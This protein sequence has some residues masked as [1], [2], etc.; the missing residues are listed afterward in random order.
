VKRKGELAVARE[1]V[2]VGGRPALVLPRAPAR[3]AVG[4]DLSGGA[5]D[6]VF[7]G[8]AEEGPVA[9]VRSKRILEAAFVFPV[10]HRTTI[11]CALLVRPDAV[12]PR[13]VAAL[14]G[15]DEVQR[16]WQAVLARGMRTELPAPAQE[17]VDAA[18]AV[19][20]LD[21]ASRADPDLVVALEDWG[22]DDE[23][24]TGWARLGTR[25]R[26][27]AARRSPSPA[28]AWGRA[29]AYLAAAS[30]A[31]AFPGGP[32]PFLAA[33]RDLLVLDSG[34]GVDLLPGFPASWLGADV[35]VHDAPT[36]A[37]RVSFGLR[38]HGPR[39]A[40]LWDA[41]AGVRL[42]AP[43]LDGT[44]VAD[45]GAG[46]SLLAEPRPTLLATGPTSAP[47]GRPLDE[48]GSFS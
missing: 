30:S 32:G 36:R 48:P 24:A 16:G 4:D 1:V 29:A 28:T 23:A 41:P 27:R 7:G 10:P 15:V 45:G 33:V 26:R 43:A 46:E 22:F 9:V 12:T 31:W 18:R 20:L 6:V 42:R 21:A 8:R 14:P 38:W 19:L 44:W 37:G 25:A 40:L 11:R 35:A 3:W 5:R 17:A 13:D 39:P 2:T 34:D 47:E